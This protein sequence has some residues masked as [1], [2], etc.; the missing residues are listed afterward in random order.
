MCAADIITAANTQSVTVKVTK[1]SVG[2]NVDVNGLEVSAGVE[3][4]GTGEVV[5]IGVEVD[6]GIDVGLGDAVIIDVRVNGVGVGVDVG[7]AVGVGVDV[8]VAVGVGV[9][10]DVGVGVG[11]DVGVA[12]GVEIGAM[13]AGAVVYISN[14]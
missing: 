10:V 2:V 12:V 9:G 8:G 14:C 13:Y 3:D 6:A 4:I 5:A 11:V 1:N 7:V